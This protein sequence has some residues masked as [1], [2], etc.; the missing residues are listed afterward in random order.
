MYRLMKVIH[1]IAENDE[2]YSYILSEMVYANI[3]GSILSIIFERFHFWKQVLLIEN[4]CSSR[5]LK[6]PIKSTLPECDYVILLAW[7]KTLWYKQWKVFYVI[8]VQSFEIEVLEIIMKDI[9]LETLIIFCY[10]SIH[11]TV[12]HVPQK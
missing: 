11:N 3:I 2:K 10:W 5:K 7:H 12:F 4:L 9:V 1:K 6:E 8:K